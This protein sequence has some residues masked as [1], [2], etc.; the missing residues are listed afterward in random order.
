MWEELQ[1]S[2]LKAGSIALSAVLIYLLL[3]AFSR[4][5][6]PRSFA[7]FT[8]F[9][10]AVTVALGAMVGAT[11]TGVVMLIH[12]VIGVSVL[13]SLRWIVARLRP[14]G[15]AKLVDNAPILL[16]NGPKI[17]PE[18]LERA[19]ITEEDLLQSLRRK[20]ITNLNQVKAVVMER[21]GSVSVLKADAEFDN[22]MLKGVQGSPPKDTTQVDPPLKE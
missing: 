21:D 19:K 18:F 3:L 20:G 1:I 2:W 14:H 15:L 9:D 13:F 6:G 10:Y 12:G 7:R 17:L 4:I 5:V 11:S 16:M 22:Y 8:A